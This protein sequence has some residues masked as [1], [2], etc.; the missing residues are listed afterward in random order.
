MGMVTRVRSA[1][2]KVKNGLFLISN[3]NGDYVDTLKDGTQKTYQS[4]EGFD[5]YLKWVKYDDRDTNKFGDQWIFEFVDDAGECFTMQLKS[6]SATAFGF[7]NRLA[8]IEKFG[9]LELTASKSTVD[10]KG[11]PVVFTHIW[12]KNVIG[13]TFTEAKGLYAKENIPQPVP[14]KDEFGKPIM[15]DGLPMQSYSAKIKFFR[16]NILPLI[17]ER[18]GKTTVA[19]A[20]VEFDTDP[21]TEY[22]IQEEPVAKKE[23]SIFDNSDDEDGVPF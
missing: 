7:L 20:D 19:N 15:K 23:S 2:L 18:V 3:P 9:M 4:S 14:I 11:S 13:K 22:H 1:F 12:V 5:T 8:S 21:D 10:I 17:Q 16:E 6:N